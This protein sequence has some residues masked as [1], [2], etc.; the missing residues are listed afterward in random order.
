MQENLLFFGIP[1]TD[2]QN[3]A[4]RTQNQSQNESY[5]DNSEPTLNRNETKHREIPKK[6]CEILLQMIYPHTSQEWHQI[7]DSIG[8]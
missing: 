8:S 4:D 6:Y 1:E 2:T 7:L 3:P 5:S